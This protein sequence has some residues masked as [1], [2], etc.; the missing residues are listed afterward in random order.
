MHLP[1]HVC[2]SSRWHAGILNITRRCPT[3][4][5]NMTCSTDNAGD[6]GATTPTS[7]LVA[8]DKLFAGMANGWLLR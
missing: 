6:T 8:D 5:G 7:L 3:N 2:L 1:A 4:A